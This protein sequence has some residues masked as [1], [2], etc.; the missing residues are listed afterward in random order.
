MKRFLISPLLL[1]V[2][3]ASTASLVHAQS[4][5][6]AMSDAPMAAKMDRAEF[7]RLF[8]WDTVSDM[9]VMRPGYSVPEGMKSRAQVKADRDMFL[10]NNRFD[11]AT[12]TWVPLGGKTRDMSTMTREEVRIETANFLRTHRWDETSEKWIGNGSAGSQ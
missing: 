10:S 6:G 2:A 9:W 8:V 1:S 5:I 3:L 7:L 11:N 12:S 4:T